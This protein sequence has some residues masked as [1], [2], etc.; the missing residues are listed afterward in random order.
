MQHNPLLQLGVTTLEVSHRCVAL[1]SQ[2]EEMMKMIEEEKK[3][4]GA[5]L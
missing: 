3:L 5:F 4:Y 1:E 2:T